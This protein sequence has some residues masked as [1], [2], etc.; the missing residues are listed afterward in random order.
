MLQAA[1]YVVGGYVP[2]E[3]NGT[4][5]VV[6]GLV[7]LIVAAASVLAARQLLDGR[8]KRLLV[9]VALWH[10]DRPSG[11]ERII[12]SM[13]SAQQLSAYGQEL[14]IPLT[15][16]ELAQI[17]PGDGDYGRGFVLYARRVFGVEATPAMG[18]ALYRRD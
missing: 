2:D 4:G 14:G 8:V 16:T 6:V 12:A 17:D 3:A 9:Q 1:G 15:A 13:P 18:E 11:Q 7:L 5:V 10:T